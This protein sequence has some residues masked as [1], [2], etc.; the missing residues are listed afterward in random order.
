M[1]GQPGRGP[2][3]ERAS[4][5]PPRRRRAARRL[6]HAA[7]QAR[8]GRLGP[9]AA[10]LGLLRRQAV[11][12]RAFAKLLPQTDIFHFYFGLT[13]VPQKSSSRS[14][15]RLG[16]SRSSTSSAPISASGRRRSSSTGSRPMPAS[17]ARSRR[18]DFIPFEA[19]V[20]PPGIDLSPYDP[21]PPVQR[22]RV[23]IVHAPSN[24]E[25][26]GTNHVIEACKQL[27]VDLDVVHGVRN[28][29]ALERYKQADIV[30][31]QVLRDWHGIFS[32]EGMA[33]GKPVV[34]SLDEDAVRQTEEAFGVKV[35]IVR[36]TKD[37]LVEKL[38]PLVG[39]VRGAQAARRSGTRLRRGGPRR[40]AD[41]RPPA[42]HLRSAL[43]WPSKRRSG[44]SASTRRSTGSAVSSSG[45]SPSCCCRSTR[46]T[47]TR[48][49]TERSRRSSRS[50]PLIF[51]VP[52]GG[53]PELVLPLLLRRRGRAG[54]TAVIRTAFWFTMG[55]ATLALIAGLVLAEPISRALFATGEHADLVR[56]AF[57][58]LWASMNY[59]QLTALFRVEERSISYSI[60]SLANVAVTIGITIVLVVVLDKGPLGVLVGNFSGTL[61]VYSVLARLPTSAA[62]ARVRSP[63]LPEDDR[64]GHAVRPLGAGAVGRSTSATASSSSSSGTSTSLACTRS[65]C[66]S[67]PRSSSCSPRS[68]P[69]GP[70]SRS[71]SRTRTRRARTFAFVHDLRGLRG[72]LGGARARPR[73][74]LARAAP[75]D[76]G[77]STR[78]RASWRSSP[79]RG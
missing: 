33:L 44:D 46:G 15:A 60:A 28:D 7:V 53:H 34:T 1:P 76:T 67:P 52:Q 9:E 4:T 38:R 35:P 39:V 55:A 71:R 79:S 27:P 23:R 61:I 13:L 72:V 50:R 64:V 48:P 11:Q 3:D 20:L 8:R 14:C 31:D 65:A 36:A 74:A 19:E 41:D 10:A 37:D 16:A 59:D 32:V 22:E 69:P 68:A 70:R 78:A 17:S 25:K 5:P 57:V 62:R 47:S 63:A 43:A 54:A 30:V 56:A 40:R 42:R 26:K 18:S 66:G 29:E 21:V 45:S 49:T 6:Q 12:W 51:D 58:G 2:L 24:L 73:L 75:D 77:R